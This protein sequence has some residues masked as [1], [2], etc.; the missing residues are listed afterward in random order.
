MKVEIKNILSELKNHLIKNYGDNIQDVV[1]FGSQAKGD[2][3]QFSD[4]DVLVVL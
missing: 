3:N 1:L 4:Y 2:S